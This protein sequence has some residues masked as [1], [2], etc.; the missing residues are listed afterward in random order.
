MQL[1]GSIYLDMVAYLTESYFIG[2]S[3]QQF[4]I[5]PPLTL[6]SFST[7]CP[8][9]SLAHFTNGGELVLNIGPYTSLRSS[10]ATDGSTNIS[11]TQIAPGE[12]Q[13]SGFGQTQ[14]FGSGVSGEPAVTSIYADAD[15]AGTNNVISLDPSVTVP[16]TLIG[17]G[18][19]DQL[20]GGA[21]N[22]TIIGGGQNDVLTGLDGNDTIQYTGGGTSNITDGNGNDTITITNGG[23]N[24]IQVGNGSDSITDTLNGGGNDT[25]Y[26]GTGNDNIN[27]GTSSGNTQIYGYLLPGGGDNTITVSGGGSYLIEGG[28]GSNTINASAPPGRW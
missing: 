22:N 3:T 25:I 27:I 2:S 12:M 5:L 23:S 15:A 10:G 4:T 1:S 11:V 24:Y 28:A 14:D 26:T 20:Q 16:A 7:S 9:E 17:S 21:G 6:F 18:A 8:P 13:V 19:S